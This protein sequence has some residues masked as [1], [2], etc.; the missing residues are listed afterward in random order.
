M[1]FTKDAVILPKLRETNP[2]RASAVIGEKGRVSVKVAEPATAFQ[3][4]NAAG[5]FCSRSPSELH[6][7]MAKSGALASMLRL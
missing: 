3:T 7:A 6:E 4:P 1:E 5:S 2:R